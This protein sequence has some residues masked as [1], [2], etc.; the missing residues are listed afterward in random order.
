MRSLISHFILS[1]LFLGFSPV[2]ALDYYS[3]TENEL[4]REYQGWLDATCSYYVDGWISED[5]AR[6]VLRRVNLSFIV[7]IV[8]LRD[9]ALQ[10]DDALDVKKVDLRY[11]S[12][13]DSIWPKF[14]I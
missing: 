11:D 9:Q 3:Q 1:F 8:H 6:D 7:Q 4:Q 5:Y 10:N 13:C 2:Q 14:S 12:R